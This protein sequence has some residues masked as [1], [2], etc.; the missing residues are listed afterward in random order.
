MWRTAEKRFVRHVCLRHPFRPFHFGI[1]SIQSLPEAGSWDRQYAPP[2]LHYA[3]IMPI[4]S[5][6][7][8]KNEP[9][10]CREAKRLV[11]QLM[12]SCRDW[13]FSNSGLEVG[14]PAFQLPVFAKYDALPKGDLLDMFFKML[15]VY[16]E[17]MPFVKSK[18]PL[19]TVPEAWGP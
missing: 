15:T 11:K 10:P 3:C 8:Q 18:S 5:L 6:H 16:K 7:L 14:L 9:V 13:A 19:P 4:P 2:V 17:S 12:N 1:P